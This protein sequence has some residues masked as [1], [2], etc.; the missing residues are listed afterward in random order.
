VNRS[1]PSLAPTPGSPRSGA[2]RVG[3]VPPE[4]EAIH[5]QGEQLM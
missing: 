5:A 2:L 4:L 3:S 1:R